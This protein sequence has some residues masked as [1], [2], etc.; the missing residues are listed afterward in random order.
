MRTTRLSRPTENRHSTG[1]LTVLAGLIAV[2]SLAGP[3]IVADPP[4]TTQPL[5]V[6]A[7]ITIHGE[8]NDIQ[9][10]AIE[11]RVGEAREAGAT[12]LIFELDTP[13]G[14]V[15]SALDICRLI[16]R[17]PDNIRTVAW[18]NP[19]AYS[20][21]SMIA[22]SCDEI[23]MSPSSSIG[24]CAPIAIDPTGGVQELSKTVRAKAE[25]PILQKFRDSAARNG[26]DQLLA[27]A[28][29]TLN[30]EVWWIQNIETGERRFVNTADKR[31]L[32]LEPDADPKT[33]KIAK[34]DADESV[35]PEWKLVESF[36][37]P[38]S[39]KEY[40]VLQ[41]VDSADEL[42][43]MSQHDAV[44]FGFARGIIADI[45]EL[46]DRLALAAVPQRFTTSGWEDFATWLSSPI[47]RGLLLIVVL[48]GGYLEFQSPGL[49]VPGATALIALAIFLAAPYAA[50]LADVW[51]IILMVLGLILLAV[52][53]LVLPGFGIAGLLGL[54]LIGLAVIGSFVPADPGAPPLSIP[55][56][57]GAWDG[58][59]T[60][61]KVLLS[62]LGIS[63]A[64]IF[65]LA[66]YLPETKL[67]RGVILANPD[68]DKLAISDYHTAVAQVGDVGVVTGDLRPGGQARFGHEIV[69]VRS[70]GE[71][72]DNGRRVQVVQREGME[73]VVRPLP[74]SEQN[75]Q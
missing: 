28:M 53:I 15:T 20:A 47:V 29:V 54:V 7:I 61:M 50:G 13:G 63:I 36:V 66:R 51:T 43:T 3:R 22:L 33:D 11:R 14:L 57:Q 55:S 68:G 58:A 1:R 31:K 41:P 5:G 60:G 40:P 9:R 48:I 34:A 64:G 32:L 56:L 38:L 24:D 18:V 37:E 71:Y 49:I 44:A 74:E 67:A 46:A 26:Y 59:M 69:D 2:A 23:W 45:G 52:E 4:P 21:G 73:I 17:T 25:S 6:G 19:E 12:T 10:D 62:S 8:I 65:L 27:R 39:G 75:Q 42:L 72:V 70:Q 35:V 16:E 30:E